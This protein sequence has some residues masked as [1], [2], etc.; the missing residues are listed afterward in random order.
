MAMAM[1]ALS[2]AGAERSMMADSSVS[3]TA[4]AERSTAVPAKAWR[5]VMAWPSRWE[6]AIRSAAQLA[7]TARHWSYT[8]TEVP[9]HRAR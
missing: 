3:R 6:S 4:W 9:Y 5:R 2:A 8:L 7:G 1:A